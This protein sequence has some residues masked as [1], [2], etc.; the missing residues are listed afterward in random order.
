MD[1]YQ[2]RTFFVLAKI[3]NFTKAA[4]S[5]FV[6]QSAVSHAVKKLESSIDSRLIERKRKVIKLTQAGKRLYKSCEKIFYE[7]EKAGQDI[8]RLNKNAKFPIRLGSSVEFGN[9]ILLNNIK[10]F[11]DTNPGIHLD[12]LFSHSLID[13][14]LKDEVDLIIDRK[15]H[16]IDNLEQIYLFREHYIT[17]ASPE[18]IRDEKIESINDIERINLISMDRDMKWWHNFLSAVDIEKP[19]VFLNVTRI[20]HITGMI[21]AAA[22]GIGV[23]FVPKYT[24][25]EKLETKI[26]IDPFPQIKPA[27]DI[28][29]IYI[30][31]EKLK[32]RQ[33]LLLI[34]YLQDFDFER[35]GKG[36]QNLR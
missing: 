26:L 29:Y 20:N 34:N 15:I 19:P 27:A 1:L 22:C 9:T 28:F 10:P 16:Q 25:M 14:L 2:L 6:T 8:S 13:P 12:F 4:E 31:K 35:F 5:L 36:E 17:I 21:N 33:N 3:K 18:Y 7:L 32:H 23:S 11:L 24:V 30:K